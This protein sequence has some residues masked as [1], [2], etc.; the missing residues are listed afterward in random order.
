VN[1][2]E[3]PA[4]ARLLSQAGVEVAILFGSAASGKLRPDSDIDIDIGILLA[5][6]RV[7]DF[8]SE[9]TLA[10]ELEQVLGREVDLVRLD[11][12][13]TLLR[14]EASQGRCLVEARPG[15]FADFVARA[16]LE[17][18]DLRP[19]LLRCA[20]GM[21]SRLKAAHDQA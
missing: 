9:L 4:V 21:F 8:A 14:F 20:A 2:I 16:L 12:A 3:S 13:S 6:D 19:I 17:H 7:L 10:T 15:A 5:P 18:E 11:E 1:A